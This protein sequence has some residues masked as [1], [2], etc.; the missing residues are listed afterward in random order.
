MEDWVSSKY[1]VSSIYCN[2]VSTISINSARGVTCDQLDE[3]SPVNQYVTCDKPE[4]SGRLSRLL[5]L[6]DPLLFFN[7]KPCLWS[8]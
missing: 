6:K 8:T 5:G 1:I 2:F 4:I 3:I 7:K